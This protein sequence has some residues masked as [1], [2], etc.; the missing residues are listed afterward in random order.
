[1]AVQY[2]CPSCG[3]SLAYDIDSGKMLCGHCGT[4]CEVEAVAGKGD[5]EDYKVYHCNSC[6]AEMI[7]DDNT[8]A[9]LCA[10]CGTPNLME[11]RLEGKWKPTRLIPFR[12]S[13]EKAKEIF[14]GWTRKGIF[15]PK[16]FR[17]QSMLDGIVGMYIPFWL[18]DIDTEVHLRVNC[19]RIHKRTAGDWIETI[20]EH[21]DVYREVASSFDKIP[22]DASTRM[23]D[24]IMDALEPYQHE[25]LRM[26]YMPYL[27]GF[28]ADKYDLDASQLETRVKDKL[29]KA[30][31]QEAMAT[32]SGYSTMAVASQEVRMDTHDE[33]Y[34][35]LPVWMLTYR[36][37]DQA[38]TLAMN[39]QTGKLVGALPTSRAKMAA[40]FAGMSV[41]LFGVFTLIGGLI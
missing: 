4:S 10:F 22:A 32:I 8:A 24:S 7:T 35:L 41:A 15:T 26:F 6:G 12:I 14:R 23:P 19:A 3:A 38:Y 39:G 28:Q 5:G 17:S 1:M 2:P 25:A 13:G 29:Q 16:A 33:E 20:T 21:Y 37:K 40:W 11:A 9:A 31:M 18:Y 30:V 27:A 36:Y 34:V